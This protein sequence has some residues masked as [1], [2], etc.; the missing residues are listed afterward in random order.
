MPKPTISPLAAGEELLARRI[1]RES[2]VALWSEP[3]SWANAERL[4]ADL[5]DRLRGEGLELVA[6]TWR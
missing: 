4:A 3:D 1:I 6:V 5:L 2:Y